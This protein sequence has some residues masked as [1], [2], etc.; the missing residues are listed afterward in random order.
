M[1]VIELLRICKGVPHV[2]IIAGNRNGEILA[3]GAA[4]NPS[5]PELNSELIP[6]YDALVLEFFARIETRHKKY[7]ELGLLPPYRT[8]ITAQYEFS[9]MKQTLYYDIVVEG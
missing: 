6:Y 3:D 4:V 8:D 1:K 7:S 9:D 2:R 5:F